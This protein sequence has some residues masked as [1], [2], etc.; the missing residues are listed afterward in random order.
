MAFRFARRVLVGLCVVEVSWQELYGRDA[1]CWG[2]S[3]GRLRG[4]EVIRDGRKGEP[5][6]IW[7]PASKLCGR[8]C[9]TKGILSWQ[10]LVKSEV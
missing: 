4:N 7:F 1:V 6:R 2:M 5:W 10:S 3:V 8:F 9:L